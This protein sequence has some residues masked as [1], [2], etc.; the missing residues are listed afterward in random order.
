MVG[1]GDPLT[2]CLSAPGSPKCDYL[3]PDGVPI[4]DRSF[5]DLAW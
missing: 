3:I 2:R 4:E 1:C 5:D